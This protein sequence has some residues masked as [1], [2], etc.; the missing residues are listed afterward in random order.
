M[1][2]FPSTREHSNDHFLEA[3]HKVY[4]TFNAKLK[5]VNGAVT[6]RFMVGTGCIEVLEM[7]T[8]HNTLLVYVCYS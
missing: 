3:L 6:M 7:G 4:N 8:F 5:E 1:C 2:S